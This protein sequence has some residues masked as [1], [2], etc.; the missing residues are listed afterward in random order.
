MKKRSLL[1]AL[2][3]VFVGVFASCKESGGDKTGGEETYKVPVSVVEFSDEDAAKVVTEAT[4]STGDYT[5][6]AKGKILPYDLFSDGMCLQRECVNRVF[7]KIDG[8]NVQNVAILFNGKEYFGEV[9]NG[10]WEVYLPKMQAGGPFEMTVVCEAGRITLKD[11]YIGEVYLLSGQSNMAWKVSQSEE[12]LESLYAD[13][14]ACKNDQIRMLSVPFNPAKT[15]QKVFLT[16]PSWDGAWAHSIKNFS[17]VGYLFGK[18]MQE[19]LGCPVG[20]I[21]TSLGAT[22]IEY[23]MDPETFDEVS[24]KTS[25]YVDTSVHYYTPSLGYNGGLYPLEGYNFRGFVWYQGCA[26]ALTPGSDYAVKFEAL[27]AML[28]RFFKN[29]NLTI[30]ACELARFY[31]NPLAYSKLNASI[32]EVAKKDELVGV[33]YNLDQGEWYDIHPKDK[34]VIAQRAADET[35]R[36]FFG[37]S[38]NAPP[39]LVDWNQVSDTKVELIFNEKVVL[40]NGSNG[41]EIFTAGGKGSY[42]CEA[43]AKGK[44]VTVTSETPFTRIRYGYTF[45]VTAETT[46][47]V[48]KTVT[49]YDEGGLPLGLFSVNL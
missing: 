13:T 36:L 9:K 17:A 25:Y 21:D 14:E 16:T 22:C 27:I 49:V 31:E 33:A 19:E 28:R 20:L 43:K 15:P 6:D 47:D 38:K 3:L 8:A 7:G 37:M 12:V 32:A 39:K 26:N 10:A 41:F 44:V 11:V 1:L 30:T 34:R 46:E 45:P 5:A 29:E 2:M 23:W 35:L 42:E 18:E 24:K 40:K 4:F 48:S